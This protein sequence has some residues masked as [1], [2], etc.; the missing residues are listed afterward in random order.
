MSS[1]SCMCLKPIG[2]VIC[3]FAAPAKLNTSDS[4]PNY[5]GLSTG[6][7]LTLPVLAHDNVSQLSELKSKSAKMRIRR[8]AKIESSV[9][10]ALRADALGIFG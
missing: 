10:P 3:E 4:K 1:E 2:P 7:L 8:P 6:S 9:S 5:I